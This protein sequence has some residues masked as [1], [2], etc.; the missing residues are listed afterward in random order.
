MNDSSIINEDTIQGLKAGIPTFV[1]VV[2]LLFSV[3]IT[4]VIITVGFTIAFFGL[5]YLADKYIPIKGNRSLTVAVGSIV[6]GLLVI[7]LI[8]VFPIGVLLM[9]I[10]AFV[11]KMWHNV[12]KA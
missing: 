9:I 3:M 4:E 7:L 8:K 12:I 5:I 10:G 11:G 6:I 1:L 2:M